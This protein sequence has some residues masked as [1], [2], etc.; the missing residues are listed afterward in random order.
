[1][2]RSAEDQGPRGIP[3]PCVSA[4][5]VR[6]VQA[7]ALDL[8]D[9]EDSLLAVWQ[10]LRHNSRLASR[11]VWRK[12]ISDTVPQK[13]SEDLDIQARPRLDDH[14]ATA[15]QY[16]P[17]SST[18]ARHF[19][20]FHAMAARARIARVRPCTSYDLQCRP[21]R[22]RL[23]RR[24]ST[25]SLRKSLGVKGCTFKPPRSFA[26]DGRPAQGPAFRPPPGYP[27]ALVGIAGGRERG[28]AAALNSGWHCATES[29]SSSTCEDAGKRHRAHDGIASLPRRKRACPSPRQRADKSR[30]RE[31]VV[32]AR[33][34]LRRRA[35]RWFQD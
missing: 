12:R 13:G 35:E 18:M 9:I 24:I 28:A 22:S 3:G 34:A 20:I 19:T 26:E 11:P 21:R 10:M 7:I 31:D 23:S 1:M 25:A 6:W 4:S 29:R 32:P 27:N 16:C 2:H 17:S 14:S 30:S 33:D 5:R 8:A 15:K